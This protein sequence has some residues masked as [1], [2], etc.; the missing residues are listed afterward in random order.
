MNKVFDDLR[1]SAID[2]LTAPVERDLRGSIRKHIVASFF[3]NLDTKITGPYRGN[4]HCNFGTI[5]LERETQGSIL[6]MNNGF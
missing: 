3:T 1:M 2:S 6:D 5:L 4:V